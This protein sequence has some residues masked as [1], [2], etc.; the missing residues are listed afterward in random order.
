MGLQL[1]FS[2][3]EFL[4]LR[5]Q[6]LVRSR[7]LFCK[8]LFL[9]KEAFTLGLSLF[10]FGDIATGDLQAAHQG[11]PPRRQ[12]GA[13]ARSVWE[14]APAASV[15]GLRD[16]FIRTGGVNQ[17]KRTPHGYVAKVTSS[18]RDFFLEGLAFLVVGLA[19]GAFGSLFSAMIHPFAT[20]P[21]A[22]DHMTTRDVATNGT[23]VSSPAL[24]LPR[25]QRTYG[26]PVTTPSRFRDLRSPQGQ[27]LFVVVDRE[28]TI[29]TAPGGHES[30]REV[31]SA[32]FERL[33]RS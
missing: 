16:T 25:S 28:R 1:F 7:E 4:G 14:P 27:D 17:N 31:K 6:F 19:A 5:L 13:G 33:T 2:G 24:S 30:P 32:A 10:A 18:P 15:G 26:N 11:A 29:D 23:P 20:P 12:W 8:R 9:G 3:S 21:R 22:H